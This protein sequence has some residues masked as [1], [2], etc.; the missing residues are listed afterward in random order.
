LSWPPPV[1]VPELDEYDI[2]GL[3]ERVAPALA[4]RDHEFAELVDS[5]RSSAGE[6]ERGVRF[7]RMF[8][9]LL[10]HWQTRTAGRGGG[11]RLAGLSRARA[12]RIAGDHRSA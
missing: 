9:A 12:R 10:T 4:R 2:A 8:E 7:Q 1:V 3:I 6:R 5:Y 11:G